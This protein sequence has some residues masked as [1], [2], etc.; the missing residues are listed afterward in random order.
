MAD[1]T[2]SHAFEGY[3]VVSADGFIADAGGVMPN[4]L[5]FD[6]DWDYFQ[7]A[8]D[9]AD[10]T[11]IGRHTHE[12]A[13]NFKKRHRLVFSTRTD[14]LVKEDA[15]TTWIDPAKADPCRAI[16][17]LFGPSANVAVVGGR[18]VFD[19]V[20]SNPSFS[21]FHL[22]LAHQARLGQG[23]TIF[24]GADDLEAALSLLSHRGLTLEHRSWFDRDAGLE[25]LV[26]RRA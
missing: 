13:P 25:L 6:A 26:Y 19:W 2:R 7:T 12:A 4:A 1:P 24:K 9:R 3:A 14:G 15:T 17:Q 21:A 5:K 11:L 8:L 23:Q 22:S 10:V 16:T 18:G 20:L